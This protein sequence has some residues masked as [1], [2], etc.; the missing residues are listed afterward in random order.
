M[1]TRSLFDA[2][3]APQ[4]DQTRVAH[5]RDVRRHWHPDTQTWDTG[6]VY[7]GRANRANNLPASLWGNPFVMQDDSPAE[8]QRVIAEY[9]ASLAKRLAQ[10][11]QRDLLEA[12]R[13]KTL[14]CWCSPNACHGDVLVEALRS[15]QP[16]LHVVPRVAA[17]DAAAWQPT[18]ACPTP[19][20]LPVDQCRAVMA[21]RRAVAFAER[22]SAEMTLVTGKRDA[23]QAAVDKL[24]KPHTK[25]L[26][27]M[28]RDPRQSAIQFNAERTKR[29]YDLLG[30]HASELGEARHDL[31]V[32]E[33]Q[34]AWLERAN[35]SI[36]ERAA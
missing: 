34:L 2:D 9:R 33:M 35:V 29:L 26:V 8:R 22:Y 7:I 6:Y 36:Q 11:G 13:S 12:L 16:A 20:H 25:T 32:A 28:K 23:A 18:D 21:H 1:T 27:A 30:T 10:P 15:A 14:V 17:F 19:W 5:F 4:P 31:H 24:T 3:S